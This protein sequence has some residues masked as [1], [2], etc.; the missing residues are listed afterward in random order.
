MIDSAVCGMDLLTICIRLPVF[1]ANMGTA[2]E[3]HAKQELAGLRKSYR[4]VSKLL[5]KGSRYVHKVASRASDTAG[6]ASALQVLQQALAASTKQL[7]S[8]CADAEGKLKEVLARKLKR[9]V[10]SLTSR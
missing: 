2:V 9:S 1:E 10:D 7:N 4:L 5:H 3:T 6:A 8:A